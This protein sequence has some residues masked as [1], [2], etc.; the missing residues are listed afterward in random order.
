MPGK[1][2]A[3]VVASE[4][5]AFDLIDAEYVRDVEPGEM[6]II[7]ASGHP[8]RAPAAAGAAA[9][10]HL[11]VRLLRAARL[12]SSAAAASTT[13]ARRS[14][15]Q[16]AQEHPVEADVVIPVPDSG[17]PAR[18]RLRGRAQACPSRWASSART[19]W[20]ARSSSRS[21]PS[22]TSA[23]VSSSTRSSRVLRGKRVVVV[24]DSIVRGTTSRKIVKMVRDAGA[25]EVHLRISSPPTQWP[26]YYGID[27]PTRRELIASS[28]SVDEIARYVTADSLGYLSLEGHARAP[29][30]APGQ[31]LPR[32]LLGAIRHPVHAQ[33][34][35]PDALRGRLVGTTGS[36]VVGGW[37]RRGRT[38][39]RPP[40]TCAFP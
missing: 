3:H 18:H 9:P 16:L 37:T 1:K 17:V 35:A 36:S 38:R 12:A 26:C 5:C 4:P 23:C 33:R 8:Q 28:H 24:D 7:D 14:A 19:T 32:V 22:A 10:V 39:P 15:A 2:D 34:Q 30:A 6:V 29:W 11:R 40:T 27:T 13:C 25:R 31:L 20:A 21:S